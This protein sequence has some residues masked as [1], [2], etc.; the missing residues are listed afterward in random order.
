MESRLKGRERA[1]E[2]ENQLGYF[3]RLSKR[4]RKKA[5]VKRKRMM[6]TA[7]IYEKAY[8]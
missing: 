4:P 6:T 1:Y 2:K 5:V 8:K 3:T 7:Q